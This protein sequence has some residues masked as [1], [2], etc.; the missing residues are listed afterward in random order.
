MSTPIHI[1]PPSKLAREE[2]I[3][4]LIKGI[5]EKPQLISYL[6]LKGRT[7]AL[8]SELLS[9]L[10]FNTELKVLVS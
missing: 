10:L 8:S 3:P 5:Y 6:M 2:N 7:Y 1:K 4:K 9:S